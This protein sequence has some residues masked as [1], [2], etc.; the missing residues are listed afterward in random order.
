MNPEGELDWLQ[1]LQPLALSMM[2]G[3][4][5]EFCSELISSL[6]LLLFC[7]YSL[8]VAL[9]SVVEPRL[10]CPVKRYRRWW[11]FIV[12]LMGVSDTKSSV[13]SWRTVSSDK[14]ESYLYSCI[15]QK[16]N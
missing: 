15:V 7:R 16:L 5:R 12:S 3:K 14:L 4:A 1:N 2:Y 11:M 6:F 10:I 8:S 9:A 13:T